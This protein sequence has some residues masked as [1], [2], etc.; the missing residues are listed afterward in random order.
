MTG[1]NAQIACI[2]L[3]TLQMPWKQISQR[4]SRMSRRILQE[5]LRVSADAMQQNEVR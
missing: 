3:E 1:V 5:L 4:I 2:C